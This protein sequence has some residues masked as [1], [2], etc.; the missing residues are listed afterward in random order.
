MASRL[1]PRFFARGGGGKWERAFLS[2]IAK[3]RE[4]MEYNGDGQKMESLSFEGT[5]YDVHTRMEKSDIINMFYQ[6]ANPA[7]NQFLCTRE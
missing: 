6:P 3:R 7:V 4:R 1:D 2:W 5:G